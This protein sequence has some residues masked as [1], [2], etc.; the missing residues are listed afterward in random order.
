KSVD[1]AVRD[2]VAARRL[3]VPL[4]GQQSSLQSLLQRGNPRHLHQVVLG[5]RGT[6]RST[7]RSRLHLR[8]TS[9]IN[10]ASWLRPSRHEQGCYGFRSMGRGS[11]RSSTALLCASVSATFAR[12]LPST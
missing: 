10:L 5:N 3:G 6:A 11:T 2:H 4:G 7:S 9:R 12:V 8:H 1:R